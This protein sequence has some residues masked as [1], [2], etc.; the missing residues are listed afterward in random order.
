MATPG[1]AESTIGQAASLA[2][3][4][5]R[6]IPV[7]PEIGGPSRPPS[8]VQLKLSATRAVTSV[9]PAWPGGGR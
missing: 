4:M 9:A 3:S 1:F 7:L 5:G 2:K 6:V 8:E